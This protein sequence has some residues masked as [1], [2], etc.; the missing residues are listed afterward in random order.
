MTTNRRQEGSILSEGRAGWLLTSSATRVSLCGP[1]PGRQLAWDRAGVRTLRSILPP[2]SSYS[3]PGPCHCSS[4]LWPFG[5][6]PRSI[7]TTRSCPRAVPTLLLVPPA[8]RFPGQTRNWSTVSCWPVPEHVPCRP[9]RPESHLRPWKQH[10]FCSQKN[11]KFH[12][13]KTLPSLSLSFLI[14]IMGLEC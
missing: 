12:L 8:P 14:C 3:W 4:L 7:Y 6:A 1:R 13:G 10:R 9:Q 2:F 11:I 5:Q